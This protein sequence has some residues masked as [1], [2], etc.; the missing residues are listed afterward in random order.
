MS[1]GGYI[2]GNNR[3][4]GPTGKIGTGYVI[5]VPLFISFSIILV[6]FIII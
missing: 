1:F 6:F 2:V 3:E 4:H 5:A